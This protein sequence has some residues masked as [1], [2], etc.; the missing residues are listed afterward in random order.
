MRRFFL[1]AV[2]FIFVLAVVVP[3]TMAQDAA[4]TIP[5][6]S[7][8]FGARL[9]PD[10]KTLVT[11]E[12][13][14]LLNLDEVDPATLPMRVIDISTGEQLGELSGYT[15]Y[16][17]DVAFTSDGSRMV[18]LHM[19]G[20]V[21]VWDVATLTATKTYQTLLMGSQQITLGQ[22][23]TTAYILVAGQPQRIAILDTET[24]AV[25]AWVGK[26]FD[27]LL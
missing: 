10:G 7:T 2:T 15:D 11:F 20:D 26:H 27:L 1:T 4:R 14:I 6:T 22:D 12:N 25:T 9:S 24:G 17:A 3:A 23:G 16:A 19:N 8:G 18:S 21:V 13:T 5:I